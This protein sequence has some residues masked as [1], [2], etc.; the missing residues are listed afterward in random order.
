MATSLPLDDDLYPPF[1]GFRKEGIEF[2]NRLKRNNTR[3]WFQ[4]HKPEYEELLRFPMECLIAALAQLMA[5]SAPEFEFHPKRSIFRI[6][7][8]TRFSADKT[9]YKTNIAASFK[10]R[11]SKGMIALP[12][13]YLG[14]EPG[15][16]YVGGGLYMPSGPQ[17]KAIRKNMVDHPE[18]FFA[19]VRDRRFKR[20]FGGIEGGRLQRTPMGYPPDHPMVEF[21]KHKQYYVGKVLD[22]RACLRASFADTTARILTDCLPFV[23]WLIFALR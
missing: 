23:R 13:L 3:V 11:G 15:E 7:R 14:I 19:V 2:L 12:G 1:H 5:E 10:L 6:Y 22:E 4:K 21:L 17:L 8:D 20:E 9:P 16:I 18:Q